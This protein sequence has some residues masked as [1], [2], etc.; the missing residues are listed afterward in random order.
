LLDVVQEFTT[1]CGMEI[2]VKT[3]CLLVELTRI[4]REGKALRHHI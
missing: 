1:W 4:I 2:N 3:T